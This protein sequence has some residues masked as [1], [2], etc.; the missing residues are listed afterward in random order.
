MSDA[1]KGAAA[2]PRSASP[3]LRLADEPIAFS[4]YEDAGGVWLSDVPEVALLQIRETFGADAVRRLIQPSDRE[5]EFF[6]A[7]PTQARPEPRYRSLLASGEF[8]ARVQAL[9]D[10]RNAK[11]PY[12][13]ASITLS[14]EAI[15]GRAGV[16][17]LVCRKGC[18]FCQ[19]RDFDEYLL[20]PEQVAER[21][22]AMQAEGAD[23]VQWLSPTAYT[24]PLLLA[25]FI[26]AKEGLRLPL[27]HKGED[28]LSDLALLDG[29][30][31][32][33]LPDA[34]FGLDASAD[35]IGLRPGYPARMKACLTAMY[36]QV[37]VLKR[38]PEAPLCVSEG[39]LVRHLLM[40]GGVADAKVVLQVVQA[41]DPDIPIHLMCSYQPLHRAAEMPGIDRPVR[42]DE[43]DEV[44][45]EAQRLGLRRV[46]VR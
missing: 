43:I 19:Y 10:L 18:H 12:F 23:T 29:V 7:L 39:L 27:V 45:A 42:E 38:R 46:Y 6:R 21:L 35:R 14:D 36:E 4:V 22:L 31:D 33:Y 24:R 28:S 2:G 9:G 16:L 20:S 30:V 1:P 8:E 40:P 41:L 32:M 5:L 37:G 3:R 34:K 44:V 15:L 26:A 13:M 17:Y 11:L 25:L